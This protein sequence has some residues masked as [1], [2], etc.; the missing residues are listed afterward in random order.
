VAIPPHWTVEHALRAF[1]MF[2]DVPGDAWARVGWALDRLG[3]HALAGVRIGKLSKGN[4]Q[5][6]AIAQ[7]LLAERTLMVLDE[8]T[9][10]LDPVWVAR[11]RELVAE[12]RDADPNRTVIL[13]SHNLPEVE[14]LADRVLL[15][16][17]GRLEGNLT[18]D[19]RTLEDALLDRV[20][21]LAEPRA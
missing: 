11:L 19:G 21:G 4:V 8:P 2:G 17:N 10:G 15:L 13:A 9:D 7:A 1:A 16:H 3:L 20:R 18:P 14:K 12:W 6:V 5:R